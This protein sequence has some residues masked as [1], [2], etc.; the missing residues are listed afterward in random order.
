MKGSINP[1]KLPRDSPS[2]NLTTPSIRRVPGLDLLVKNWRKALIDREGCLAFVYPL[3]SPLVVLLERRKNLRFPSCQIPLGHLSKH[4]RGPFPTLDESKS[5]RASLGISSLPFWGN[6]LSCQ[7]HSKTW[8]TPGT[9]RAARKGA[10]PPFPK[11]ERGEICL[12]FRFPSLLCTFCHSYPSGI[13]HSRGVI[14]RGV[15]SWVCASG[16][17]SFVLLCA[18]TKISKAGLISSHIL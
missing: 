15:P 5:A 8:A 4:Y 17:E 3:V 16:D 1:C 11:G 12:S 18:V 10:A 2:H 14:L 13:R 7:Q 9:C 6:F